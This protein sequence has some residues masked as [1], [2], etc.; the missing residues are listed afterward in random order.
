MK[1]EKWKLV[2]PA[3][4][5]A[6][7][8]SSVHIANRWDPISSNIP[9]QCIQTSKLLRF[10]LFRSSYGVYREYVSTLYNSL[11]PTYILFLLLFN[12]NNGNRRITQEY[13][14]IEEINKQLFYMIVTTFVNLVPLQAKNTYSSLNY[15]ETIDRFDVLS[16]TLNQLYLTELADSHC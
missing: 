16:K 4:E 8:P 2:L 14:K 1:M 6:I 7:S 10:K 3:I 15:H 5:L 13:E 11:S 12:I 9:D